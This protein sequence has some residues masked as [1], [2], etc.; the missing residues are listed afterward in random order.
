[1]NVIKRLN[2][3]PAGYLLKRRDVVLKN[4]IEGDCVST[5]TRSTPT[6]T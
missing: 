5:A 2:G 3:K 4:V 1:M 6:K